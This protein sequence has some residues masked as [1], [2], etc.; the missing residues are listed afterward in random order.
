MIIEGLLCSPRFLT[1]TAFNTIHGIGPHTARN[2]YSL[3]LRTIEDLEKYYEATAETTLEGIQSHLQA[4][5][6]KEIGLDKSIQV[7]LILRH[8]FSQK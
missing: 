3:G 4:G 8:H 7:S 6:S 1:L 2:L 5:H